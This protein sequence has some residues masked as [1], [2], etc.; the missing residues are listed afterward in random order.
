V[1]FSCLL[2]FRIGEG[3]IMSRLTSLSNEN[4]THTYFAP[5]S[6][7]MGSDGVRWLLPRFGFAVMC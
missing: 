1:Q 3:R 6:C 4:F 7:G 5:R 2:G